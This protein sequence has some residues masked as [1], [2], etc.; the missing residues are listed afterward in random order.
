MKEKS[1][2]TTEDWWL[3]DDEPDYIQHI[4]KHGTIGECGALPL[5]TDTSG[6]VNRLEDLEMEDKIKKRYSNVVYDT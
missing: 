4:L 5:I 1:V 3:L 6:M 2:Q